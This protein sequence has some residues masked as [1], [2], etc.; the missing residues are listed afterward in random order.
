MRF[1]LHSDLNNFYAS[2]ECLKN[3]KI[4][5]V[6]VV[7]VG[8]EEKRH[9]I[10]LSKNEM[11]KAFGIKTG[12]TVWEARQKASGNLTCVGA[13]FSDYLNISYQ[14]KDI[15][16]TYSDKVESFGIDEAWIDISKIARTFAEAEEVAHMIRRAVLSQIGIS[17]SI[18]VSFNKVF[19]K[20]GSDLKKPNAVTVITPQDYQEKVWC[21]PVQ[22]LLYVGRAT[23]KTLNRAGIFT[24]GDLAKC[25]LAYLKKVF[26]KNG[27]MLYQYANGLENS[28]VKAGRDQ[29]KSIGNSTT[30]PHDLRTEEEVKAVLYVLAE[31]VVRRMRKKNWW[32]EE[33]ALYVKDA[34][35]TSFERQKKLFYPTNLVADLVKECL[36][37]FRQN[38]KWDHTVRAL[39]VRA[40]KLCDQPLQLN[41]FVNYEKNEKLMMMEQTVEKLR[42]RFGDHV[43]KR[44]VVAKDADFVELDVA[45][46]GHSIMSK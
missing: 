44:G 29:E 21:L 26:G 43:L 13:N 16:R 17:V 18:G 11:A 23:N 10:V 30:C 24:V 12:D 20:L 22:A 40:G 36:A 6:P 41:M 31:N 42:C 5:N 4:R 46:G 37:L 14:V 28:D 19:A 3:P 39:G 25:E 7:V 38:Y 32:C 1:V 45:G 2:V 27:V 9:G 8:D 33:I 34:T 35:L 15:Y